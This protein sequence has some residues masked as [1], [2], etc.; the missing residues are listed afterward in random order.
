MYPGILNWHYCLGLRLDM[1]KEQDG[2]IIVTELRLMSEAPTDDKETEILIK[3]S[4]SSNFHEAYYF[5]ANNKWII[6]SAGL[7]I[8]IEHI[9]GWIHKPIYKSKEKPSCEDAV[10]IKYGFHKNHGQVRPL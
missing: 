2:Q 1:I 9:D 3:L 7:T 4:G 8:P 10:N 5:Q 6:P